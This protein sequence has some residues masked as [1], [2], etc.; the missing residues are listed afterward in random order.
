MNSFSNSLSSAKM[1]SFEQVGY[2]SPVD[3]SDPDT[4]AD[5]PTKEAGKRRDRRWIYDSAFE[6]QDAAQAWL[7]EEAQSLW[8]KTKAPRIVE[9]GERVEYRCNLVK[10][11]G[12]Q[13]N[14]AIYLLYHSTSLRV[15]LYK[16]DHDHNYD[17]INVGIKRQGI[18][19]ATKKAIDDMLA[20]VDT[21]WTP[22]T[23][24]NNL[25]KLNKTDP[26]IQVPT[27]L[28]ISNYL[29]RKQTKLGGT[30]IT[31]SEL[32]SWLEEHRET[33][34]GDDEPFVVSYQI[35]IDDDDP[36]SY[37]TNTP[38]HRLPT[39]SF[40]FFI[41]TKRLIQ[42]SA[43]TTVI[44]ADSTYKLIWHKFPVQVVGRSD[45]SN[46]FHPFGL[47]VCTNER[48]HDY[49]FIF[50]S[51]LIGLSRLNLPPIQSIGLVADAA[52]AI[53]NGFRSAFYVD[54]GDYRRGMCW[55]HACAAIE[56]ELK[57]VTQSST[58][59]ING[60]D[61]HVYDRDLIMADI[62]VIQ[63]A[64][65]EELFNKAIELFQVKWSRHAAFLA[66][67]KREWLDRHPGWYEGYQRGPSTNNGL[68]SINGDIKRNKTFRTLLPLGQFLEFAKKVTNGWS[69]ARCPTNPDPTRFV[70]TQPTIDTKL[71]TEA[72]HWLKSD[73]R[74]TLSKRT[75]AE[76]IH[77]TKASNATIELNSASIKRYQTSIDTLNF[78]SFDQYHAIMYSGWCTRFPVDVDAT[79]WLQGSCTCP[80]YSKNNV[81]K[82]L[83]GLA[84]YLKVNPIPEV[85]KTVPIGQKRGPG[86]PKKARKALV[87][88]PDDVPALPPPSPEKETPPPKP[89]RNKR[90]AAEPV[91]EVDE[92]RPSR[93]RRAASTKVIA[94]SA[95]SKST[96]STITIRKK[97]RGSAV[98]KRGI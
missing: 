40:R 47:A 9:S 44:Q 78:S 79:S 49:E 38:I 28:Q 92:P 62:N 32:T 37:S 22:T 27:K 29:S 96:S 69:Y 70:S 75:N 98:A 3:E 83:V 14:A 61:V 74:V 10:K 93:P 71:Y 63:A 86:R 68:E 77:F 41:S 7:A 4:D 26:N 35:N 80:Y 42:I 57:K 87:Y 36:I 52:D 82:H 50:N 16:T 85:A 88:Q 19:A 73:K 39:E 91:P 23:I 53:T 55:Y 1:D 43:E 33:L 21:R 30:S 5:E 65:S 81:C 60:Q 45:K 8:S 97:V 31:F 66:Y 15:S 46:K 89:S 2:Q 13:C 67:F 76:I 48:E 11:R 54:G 25:T 6:D 24:F 90:K 84:A 59:S 20:I 58:K 51:V 17:E 95:V 72:Y 34:E 56:N 12:P 64:L 18:T 94:P